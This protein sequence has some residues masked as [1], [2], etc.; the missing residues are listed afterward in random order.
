MS[1]EDG[2]V[3]IDEP[4]LSLHVDWQRIILGEMMK[5]V[6]NRQV[7][8][9]TH[10]PEIAAE[11]LKLTRELTFSTRTRDNAERTIFGEVEDLDDGV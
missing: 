6:G 9:C 10:S 3:L 11:H 1:Q 8:A 4:E 5:Q 2:I 7:I